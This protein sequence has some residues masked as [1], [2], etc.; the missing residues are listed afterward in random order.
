M[1]IKQDLMFSNWKRE[2]YRRK[3]PTQKLIFLCEF[4]LKND[5]KTIFGAFRSE[6]MK[7]RFHF[8]FHWNPK[9]EETTN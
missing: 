9:K 7:F 4:Q 6:K 3:G 8:I 1:A 5:W 2:K